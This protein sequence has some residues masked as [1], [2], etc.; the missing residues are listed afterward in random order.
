MSDSADAPTRRELL[1][2]V[3]AMVGLL[4]AGQ[5]VLAL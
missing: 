3:A 2:A 5:L 4:A 1:L